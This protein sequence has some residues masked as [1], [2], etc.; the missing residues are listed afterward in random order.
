MGTTLR[1]VYAR[2]EHAIHEKFFYL[3]P[4]GAPGFD[5]DVAEA[6]QFEVL[7]LHDTEQNP[8]A[9]AIPSS[10]STGYEFQNCMLGLNW[11]QI[12]SRGVVGSYCFRWQLEEHF[13]YFVQWWVE[14]KG[15]QAVPE[16]GTLLAIWR[17]GADGGFP[18]DSD[19]DIKLYQEKYSNNETADK[20]E[21]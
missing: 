15:G 10:S 13:R 8:G 6:F 12:N 11:F 7:R 4:A 20:D 14:E 9:V 2:P 5:L 17:N 3:S 16:E 21:F 18:W 19:F 1:T